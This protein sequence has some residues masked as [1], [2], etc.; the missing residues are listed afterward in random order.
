MSYGY[1]HV[2]PQPTNQQTLTN[3]LN[4]HLIY[5]AHPTRLTSTLS[6]FQ[7]WTIFR[8]FHFAFRPTFAFC[9]RQFQF[10]FRF[11]LHTHNFRIVFNQLYFVSN[12]SSSCELQT[13][14]ITKWKTG[15]KLA[16]SCAWELSALIEVSK[17]LKYSLSQQLC[18]H[19]SAHTLIRDS[20]SICVHIPHAYYFRI[21]DSLSVLDFHLPIRF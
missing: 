17:F 21:F 8:K 1:T 20:L 6:S 7:L 19:I 3:Q 2:P 12:Y 4:N 5:H 15:E 14:F 11:R 13:F 16:L 9:T 10:Q 18:S